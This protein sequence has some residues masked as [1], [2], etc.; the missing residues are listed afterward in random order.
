MNPLNGI[1][2]CMIV[3]NEAGCLKKALSSVSPAIQELIVVDTGSFDETTDIAT[4]HGAKVFPYTWDN[5]FSAARNYSIGL[6][7]QPW[8]LVMDADETMSPID[9]EKL[10]N[11][12][13]RAAPVAYSLVQRNYLNTSGKLSWDQC[14]KENLHEYDEGREFSGYLDIPVARLFPRR[15]GIRFSGCVHESVEDSLIEAGISIER[16]GLVLHH[17]GQVRTPEHM[18]QKKNLYLRLGLEKLELAPLNPKA[19]FELGI[20]YNELGYFVEAIPHFE[21]A[22]EHG[23]DSGLAE[24]YLGIC[25]SRLERFAEA[26]QH[27]LRS[28]ET[29]PDSAELY[30]ELGLISLREGLLED[31]KSGFEKALAITPHH[32]GSLC[33]LGSILIN[34][35]QWT[36]GTR[37]LKQALALDPNHQDSWVNLGLAYQRAGRSSEAL[38]CQSKAYSLKPNNPE[39]AKQLGLGL[40]RSGQ[41]SEAAEILGH[42]IHREP[43]DDALKLIWAMT[44]VRSGQKAQALK[45]YEEVSHNG[46][47]LALIAQEQMNKHDGKQS[48]SQNRLPSRQ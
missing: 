24:L 2:L 21:K 19:H 37:L 15:P 18:K 46:G 10:R 6:A 31:A 20:Q 17:Y 30:C 43:A 11:L 44:L 1:S 22:I 7:T 34:Q 27:L 48:T 3:K 4:S 47:G 12:V 41:Y 13:G 25:C 16:S 39:L 8:I 9:L 40:A 35:E 26:R 32:V 29:R 5:D 42:F 33:Y 28:R 45:V 36:E 14:W 23:I 38:E